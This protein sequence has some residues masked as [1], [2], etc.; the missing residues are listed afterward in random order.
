MGRLLGARLDPGERRWRESTYV[1][2]A[3]PALS[4]RLRW[5]ALVGGAALLVRLPLLSA[6]AGVTPGDGPVYFQLAH[7][8]LDGNGLEGNDYRTPGYPVAIL[9]AL[10]ADRVL[11][12]GEAELVLAGQNLLGILLALA[13][14]LVG[15]RHFGWRVGVPAGLLAAIAP[16]LLPIERMTYPDL[17]YACGLFAGAALL[18]E[19]AVRGGDRRWL[20]ASGVAFGLSAYVKPAAQ[21]MLIVPLLALLLSTRGARR[22]WIGGAVAAAAMLVTIG[23]WLIHNALD[24][25]VGM[26]QQGGLTL[27]HRA[28]DDDGLAIPT[29]VPYGKAMRRVQERGPSVAH[30][31][32]WSRVWTELDGLRLTQDEAFAAMGRAART[33]IR[34]HPGSY[35]VRTAD[36]VRQTVGDLGATSP[37]D[38]EGFDYH[39]YLHHQLR[40]ARVGVPP[41]AI[42]WGLVQVG[43]V[44]GVAWLVVTLYGA[45]ALALPFAADERVRAAGCAFLVTWL[46]AAVTTALGHGALWRYSAALAPL[47]WLAG[48]AGAWLVWPE[49]ARRAGSLRRRSPTPSHR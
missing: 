20:A 1:R 12:H 10:L 4:P 2:L 26:N 37:G 6:N 33:A 19:G 17:L 9:P 21:P 27:F 47:A 7:S 43:L 42:S 29:D 5:I 41:D 18:A 25:R 3:S 15:A 48:S 45:S 11:G 44:L 40:A 24:G 16:V 38:F 31:R 36:D 23:P 32:Y 8:L 49:L 13:V 46:V 28:F 34:R 14:L 35:A 39:A 30:H 22:A